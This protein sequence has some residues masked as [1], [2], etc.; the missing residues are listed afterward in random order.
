[1]R[2][3]HFSGYIQLFQPVIPFVFIFIFAGC[4]RSSDELPVLPPETHPLAREYVGFGV[5]NA[6]FTH[7]LSDPGPRGAS[8]GYFRRGTVVRIIERR[9][10]NNRGGPE[11]WVLAEGNYQGSQESQGLRGSSSIAR[12][13]LLGA[14]VEVYDSEDKAITA[15]KTMNQ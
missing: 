5:V 8:Q 6:S 12:G 7:F 15:S 3:G 4:N 11:L 13:W 9:Q 14:T 2:I 10:I 1:M